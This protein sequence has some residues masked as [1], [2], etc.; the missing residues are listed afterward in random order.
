MTRSITNWPLVAIKARVLLLAAESSNQMAIPT[1]ITTKL[2]KLSAK[3]V[4]ID[5]RQCCGLSLRYQRR[6]EA[7]CRSA[8]SDG[9][10]ACIGLGVAD[11]ATAVLLAGRSSWIEA[12]AK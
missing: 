10:V 2:P 8:N 9:R 12:C 7:D 11:P 3:V 4:T 5:R 6:R 1:E